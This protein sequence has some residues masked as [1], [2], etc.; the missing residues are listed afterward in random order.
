MFK[1]NAICHEFRIICVYHV[2]T[3]CKQ[4]SI[5]TLNVISIKNK[6]ISDYLISNNTDI[7]ALTERWLGSAV[8]KVFCQILFKT[9]TI[10]SILQDRIKKVDV[11]PPYIN[12]TLLS[13]VFRKQRRNSHTLNFLNAVLTQK[14]INYVIYRSPPAGKYQL[15][16]S[17]F[18]KEWSD[19]LDC[20]VKIPEEIILTGDFNFHL[21]Y[22][23][24]CEN[25][26]FEETISDHGLVQHLVGASHIRGNTL[27][28][29]ICRENCSIL[30]RVP[31]IEDMRIC[32]DKSISSL[33]H[34]AVLCELNITKTPKQRKFVCFPKFKEINNEKIR[35]GYKQFTYPN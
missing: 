17:T 12:Q 8:D 4:L 25:R 13:N 15:K 18:F 20:T 32:D 27:D 30:A 7:L 6:S 5:T 21:D 23:N 33:D 10:Y 2:Q 3:T 28:V 14:T 35:E 1:T 16:N 19:F 11:L 31:S 29:I 9:D 26:K 24:N 34:F 22:K